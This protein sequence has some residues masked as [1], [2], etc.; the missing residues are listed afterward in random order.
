[1]YWKVSKMQSQFQSET[2]PES[3]GESQLRQAAPLGLG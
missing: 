2:V 1:M 3:V